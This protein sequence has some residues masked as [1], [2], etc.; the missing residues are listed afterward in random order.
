MLRLGLNPYG[1]TYF[2]GLQGRGTARANPDG[3]GLEG[4]VEAGR[5]IE[6]RT[7]EL[8]N[9]WLTEKTDGELGALRARL[10]ELG[11]TPVISLGPPLEGVDTAIRS[12][13]GVGATLIRLGLTPVLCGDRNA[14]G[15][16]WPELLA[17]AG[18]TLRRYA[19]QAAALGLTFAIEDHQ[20]LGS[21]E[22][23]DFCAQG[24]PNVGICLDTGNPFAVGEEPIAFARRV[25]P[26]V[27]HVHLKDYNAQWTDEGYRLVRCAIGDGAVPFPQIF[28]VLREHHESLTASLEPGALE[29][30]HVRLFRSEWWN[31]YPPTTAAELGPCLA[32]ARRNRLAD[33]ADYRTPWEREDPPA[34]IIEYEREMVRRS[35]ANMRAIG[36]L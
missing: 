17:N 25:A 20:D 34:A 30:R 13:L 10:E 2:L 36:L 24:G 22:L 4:F 35:A 26:L 31:G 16:Q 11:M 27:R 29:A 23:I 9:P 18:A 21:R 14:C 15:A 28:A 3:K 19:P 33:D 5:E 6:A 8:H 1:L 32:A 7:L 12:A